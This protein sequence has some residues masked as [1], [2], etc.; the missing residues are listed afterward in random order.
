MVMLTSPA[1]RALTPDP[2]PR[3]TVREAAPPAAVPG[4]YIITLRPDG[5]LDDVAALAGVQPIY[6][7][8]KVMNGFAARM[9][10]EQISRL[11]RQPEV[12]SIEQDGRIEE[13][14]LHTPEAVVPPIV[15]TALSWGRDRIDQRK[16]P[17]NGTF[18]INHDGDGVTAYMVGSGISPSQ[19][20]FTG[21]L[22]KGYSAIIDGHGTDDCLGQGTFVAGIVGGATQGVAPK[23]RMVP[24][25]VL[26][27]DGKGTF[28]GMIAALDWVAGTI[29]KP[30]VVNV[31]VGGQ[32]SYAANDA[33]N[34]LAGLGAF[35]AAAAG[36]RSSDA[37]E[38]S[39]AGAPGIIT[40]AASTIKDTPAPFSN[41][42]P[43]VDLYA[44]GVDIVSS[45]KS[46]GLRRGSGTAY[47]TPFVTGVAA[48]L[49]QT[50]GASTATTTR[51]WIT[52]NATTD[53]LHG[54]H[55]DTPNRLLFTG[56]L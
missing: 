49:K 33:A 38:I 2:A 6:R 13:L 24:V 45:A 1:A 8:T 11:R 48:L 35:I 29:Q 31:S 50:Y 12:A 5:R 37:C 17:L 56:D 15:P 16:L 25:R 30:A 36:D 34:E 3:V 19:G 43:C 46:G 22:D 28:A 47:A 41:T 10:A 42:G 18:K 44:P 54:V 21:R 53:A 14:E 4:Q 9:T 26:D 51:N 23:V 27:C 55:P 52:G 40:V 32:K 39:P 7:Y 20:E